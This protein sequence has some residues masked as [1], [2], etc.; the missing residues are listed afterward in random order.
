MVTKQDRA[1]EVFRAIRAQERS[2][3][4]VARKAEMRDHVLRS[5]V[6][7]ETDFTAEEIAKVAKVL[8]LNLLSLVSDDVSGGQL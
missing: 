3:A 2:V 4:W 7:A 1:D 5:R 6:R 8:G